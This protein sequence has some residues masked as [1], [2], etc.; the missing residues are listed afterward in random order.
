MVSHRSHRVPVA[1]AIGSMPIAFV[2]TQL[3]GSVV[4]DVAHQVLAT[5]GAEDQ[6][7][8]T[9]STLAAMG[10][11]SVVLLLVAMATVLVS[12]LALR[13]VFVISPAPLSVYAA[14]AVGTVALGPLADLLMQSMAAFWPQWTLG[15]V[16]LLHDLAQQHSVWLLWPFFALLPG[17]AEE[18]FFRGMLQGAFRRP[19]VA[20]AAGGG[21]FALFHLDPHHIA[22]VLPLG[23]FLSWVAQ[24]HG[25]SVTIVAHVINNTVALVSAQV[26]RLDVGYGTDTPLPFYWVPAGLVITAFAMWVLL[27]PNI[28]AVATSAVSADPLNTA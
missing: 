28:S 17:I 2:A 4:R 3:G 18:A 8:A 1:I 9:G 5:L 15:S 13:E 20:I 19:E 10:A 27:R 14:A 22:G 24:R 26:S 7:V 23:L 11:T 6:V 21:A 12:G 25:L 16:S